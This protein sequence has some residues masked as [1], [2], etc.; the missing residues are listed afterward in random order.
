[1][2]MNK[3]VLCLALAIAIAACAAM[4]K[5]SAPPYPDLLVTLE[6]GGCYGSCPI[7]KLTIDGKGK[8]IYEGE[9][10]V[11]VKGRR[12]SAVSQEKIRALVAAVERANYFSL[13]DRYEP[14][15]TDLPS[16]TTSIRL[17][18]KTKSIYHYGALC[19]E[20]ARPLPGGEKYEIDYGAPKELCELEE[21]IDEIANVKRW[22]EK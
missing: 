12:E 2:K 18:G 14:Q 9:E 8:V 22:V 10:F 4:E 15:I 3:P 7:Y 5:P 16:V 1:M 20:E 21:A 19:G 17:R 6:R 11:A 13:A